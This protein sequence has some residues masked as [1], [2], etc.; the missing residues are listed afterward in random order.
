MRRSVFRLLIGFHLA[1]VK[2]YLIL[3]LKEKTSFRSIM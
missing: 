1:E 3:N 2:L